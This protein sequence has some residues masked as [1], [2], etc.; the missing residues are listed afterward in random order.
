MV[1]VG[2]INPPTGDWPERPYTVID[3]TPLIREKP[4]LFI[5]DRGR[6]FVM[7]APLR[8]EGSRG[9][10]WSD[11]KS[12]EA[13]TKI[14]IDEFY[15]AHAARDSAK[16]INEALSRGKHLLL[17]PGIYHLAE[18]IHVTRAG[19]VV[20][21]LGYPTLVPDRGTQAI[22]IADV[23]RV[24]ATGVLL[25]A[26]A[27]ESKTLLE[28]GASGASASHSSDPIFLYDIFCRA[29]GATPGMTQS[30]VTINSDNVVGDNFWLWRADH[31]AGAKWD[32]NKNRTGLIVNGNDVTIYGLF[33]EHCQEY[34][35]IWN[36]NGGRVYFYQ[37]E[38]P[39]D[40]PTQE[41]WSHDGVRGFASYK[42]ADNVTSHEAWGLGVYC[43]F[44]AGPIIADTA[45][46]APAT[47]PSV[48]LHHMITVRLSGK[49]ESGIAH[50]CNKNGD[51]VITARTARLDSN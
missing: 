1:F 36:G 5:D 12:A 40:P 38:M 24:K 19:T 7:V 21:G 48:K 18:P 32:V 39:Y 28:V 3:K 15:I 30:F 20:L 31:G 33:V 26:G 35:T 23:D 51:P 37:S 22:T 16:S 42:V 10:T 49:P 8:A 46:A 6:F 14:S 34:Q 45:I 43:V 11:A 17:T 27:I 4:Y 47:A 2:T 44:H 41:A 25:D 50:V 9:I 13:G 29:G